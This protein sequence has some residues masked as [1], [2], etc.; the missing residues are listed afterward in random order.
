MENFE[1]L[2]KKRKCWV[3]GLLLFLAVFLLPLFSRAASIAGS[4]REVSQNI[5]KVGALQP[6]F[7]FAVIG[8]SRDGEKV[9]RR[10]MKSILDRG[11]SF[12][13]HLGDMV[14]RPNEKEWRSFF[15]ISKMIDLPFFPVVGNH[16]VAG[17]ARGEEMYRKKFLLPGDQT[18]FAFQAGGVLSVILD[19]EKGRGRILR[20]QW[21]WL[22]KVLSSSGET[23]KLVFTHRPLFLPMDSFKTG[24]AMDRYPADRDNLH[25]LFAKAKVKAV[26]E[27]DDHRYDRME[28]DGVFY[29]ITGGGGAPIYSFEDSGGYFHYV[30]VSVQNRKMECE[31]VDLEGRTRDRWV[32]NKDQ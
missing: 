16:E 28:K 1:T 4:I 13:I 30:W 12:V 24:R 26:F 17:T 27:A 22:E 5:E 6:P 15:E 8:D 25:R 23:S 29:V 11:P 32:I 3:K 2:F 14:A 18:Y 21:A 9:Y 10:L 20:E 7:S 31:A 19:S